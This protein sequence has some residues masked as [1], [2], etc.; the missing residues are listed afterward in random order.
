MSVRNYSSNPSDVSMILERDE[1][2]FDVLIEMFRSSVQTDETMIQRS[3]SE[4]S[5]ANGMQQASMGCRLIAKTLNTMRRFVAAQDGSVIIPVDANNFRVVQRTRF[6]QALKISQV[7]DYFR[8]MGAGYICQSRGPKRPMRDDVEIILEV[9]I[10]YLQVQRFPFGPGRKSCYPA[11]RELNALKRVISEP[12]PVGEAERCRFRNDMGEDY[13]RFIWTMYSQPSR[14]YAYTPQ[15]SAY[16]V[17]VVR[18]VVKDVVTL[19]EIL[20]DEVPRAIG[21]QI[22]P[23]MLASA[24]RG[25][26]NTTKQ[27]RQNLAGDFIRAAYALD[28]NWRPPVGVL[29]MR[30]HGSPFA[31]GGMEVQAGEQVGGETEGKRDDGEI[32]LFEEANSSELSCGGVSSSGSEGGTDTS[33]LERLSSDDGSDASPAVLRRQHALHV[34]FNAALAASNCLRLRLQREGSGR[35]GATAEGSSASAQAGGTSPP[36]HGGV[37]TERNPPPDG[38]IVSRQQLEDSRRE[39]AANV[40]AYAD[41]EGIVVEGPPVEKSTAEFLDEVAKKIA[42]LGITAKF[43]VPDVQSIPSPPDEEEEL[44]RATKRKRR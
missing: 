25:G 29:H 15:P 7:I 39:A 5:L 35:A 11:Y 30:E 40:R 24:A 26:R 19:H 16:E 28:A 9:A 18:G 23:I 6:V 3:I 1:A 2:Q 10:L 20:R 8:D 42:R 37:G 32:E 44:G 17:T 43:V 12:I 36:A 33:T 22:S 21:R 38:G 41:Y 4:A 34:P 14:T 13:M 31:P 27:K